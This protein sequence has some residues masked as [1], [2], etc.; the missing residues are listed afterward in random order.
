MNSIRD[1]FFRFRDVLVTNEVQ[2]GIGSEFGHA[3]HFT[4]LAPPVSAVSSPILAIPTVADVLMIAYDRFI[5][6]IGNGTES[7]P[8]DRNWSV[9]LVGAL[10]RVAPGLCS[11][12][13][14]SGMQNKI[15]LQF[16]LASDG[17][18]RVYCW[19]W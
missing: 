10:S 12:T 5:A 15:A 13:Q 1:S 7:F 4:A 9:E 11:A 3:L 17:S 6:A 19:R 2:I 8:A 16:W 18:S 14:F